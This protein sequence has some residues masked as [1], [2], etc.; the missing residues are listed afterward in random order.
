MALLID[1]GTPPDHV[2]LRGLRE[3]GVACPHWHC[4]AWGRAWSNPVPPVARSWPRG[5]G[6]S[7]RRCLTR[8]LRGGGSTRWPAWS[9]SRCARSPRPGT[10]GSPRSASGSSA[11]AR[12]TWPGCAPRGIRWR[13]GTGCRMRRRSGSSWTAWT[14]A[15]WPGPCSA[16]TRAAAGA[17]AGH[18]RPASAPTLPG[19]SRKR[20]KRWPAAG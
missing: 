12:P 4:R 19:T 11:P 14:R 8:V 18:P 9:R 1:A 7:W 6:R 2:G 5:R 15:P 13:A 10:T 16:A 17:A 3:R 20:R